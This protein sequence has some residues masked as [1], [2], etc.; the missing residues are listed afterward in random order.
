MFRT[1]P[2]SAIRAG[3]WK[4][5][6]YFEDGRIELYDLKNDMGKR[7]NLS[8]KHPDLARMLHNTL[9]EWKNEVGSPIPSALN[10]DY[11]AAYDRAMR[12]NE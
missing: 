6:E 1:R 7:Q 12:L 11:D 5:H 10:P 3:D 4:L 9:V 8:E 2:G